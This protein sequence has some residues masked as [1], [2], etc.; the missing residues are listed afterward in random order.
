MEH[1][2]WLESAAAELGIPLQPHQLAQ[3][4]RYYERLVEVNKTMNLTAITE[5]KD[6]YIK[7]FYDSLTLAPLLP[8]ESI[9]SLIDVGTGA[10]FPG[11]PLKIAFPH[12]RLTM[13]DSL[14]KRVTFLRELAEDLGLEGVEAVHGRAE[15]AGRQPRFRESFDVATARAVARLNVL[16]EYCMPF[17]R[18]GGIFAAMK[19]ADVLEE[20]SEAQ[21]AISRLGGGSIRDE[22]LSLPEGKGDRHILLVQKNKPTPKKYPRRPGIPAKQPI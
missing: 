10:G 22:L 13:L 16:S 8:A 14:N 6:V 21:S 9:Q 5:E 2:Q 18:V 11:I 1:R 15:E 3:F 12:I 20:I 4:A 17:V 19:G 7:H